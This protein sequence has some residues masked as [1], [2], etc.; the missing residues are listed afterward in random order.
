MMRWPG[1]DEN[2]WDERRRGVIY[3]PAHYVDVAML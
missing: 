1:E 2:R 3:T